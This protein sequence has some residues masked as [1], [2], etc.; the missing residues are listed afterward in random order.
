M[1]D[2][3][4]ALDILLHQG[5]FGEVYNIGADHEL[6]TTQIAN[7]LL[8]ILGKPETLITYVPDRPGNDLRYSISAEQI[9][10]EFGWEPKYTFEDALVRTVH[11]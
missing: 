9:K 4:E 3:C 11:W 8:H 5:K 1:R 6:N 10:K 2:H 7:T